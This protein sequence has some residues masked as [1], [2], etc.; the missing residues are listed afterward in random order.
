MLMHFVLC[1]FFAGATVAQFFIVY[2]LLF[3]GRASAKAIG[4]AAYDAYVKSAILLCIV[5][6]GYPIAWVSLLCFSIK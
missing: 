5:W 6:I 3:P 1:R 2:M 4:A